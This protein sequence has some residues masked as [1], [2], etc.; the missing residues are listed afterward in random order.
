MIELVD[1]PSTR[2][3]HELGTHTSLLTRRVYDALAPV[4]SIP[5]LLFHSYAHA[6]A[7]AASD[8][9]NGSRVLEVAMGSGEMF[10]DL[11]KANPG[12]ETTG[13]DLSP[14]MAAR[15]QTIVRRRYPSV[16]AHC[17]AADVR[18]L[19]FKSGHFDLIVVCY[20]FELLPTE[21]IPEALAELKRVL[22]PGGRL[23]T[24]LIGQNKRSFNAMYKVCSRVAP[25]F[26]GRQAEGHTANLLSNS[27]LAIDN[28][29]HIQQFWYSSR[30]I[31]GVNQA[32]QTATA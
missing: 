30:V 31:S 29:Q 27:G 16:K 5:T 2:L 12:G 28:D 8:V 19:P 3:S 4:Y 11:V 9:E 6:A 17:Q 7:L 15:S 24:I 21:H 22:K 25:A 18:F 23:T 13:I 20:L 14:K 1:E 10:R 26:W 32:A